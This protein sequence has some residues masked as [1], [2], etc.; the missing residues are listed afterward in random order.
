VREFLNQ[1]EQ[2]VSRFGMFMFDDETVP[3]V[4]AAWLRAPG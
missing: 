3:G 2:G 1:F 4:G